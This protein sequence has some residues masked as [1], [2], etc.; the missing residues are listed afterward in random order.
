MYEQFEWFLNDFDTD[1]MGILNYWYDGEY[2]EAIE[3]IEQFTDEDWQKLLSSYK[4]KSD[5]WKDRM[6]YCFTDKNNPYQ[7]QILNDLLK[8]EN[9]K[10][11]IK[12]IDV[13]R[14]NFD[15]KKVSNIEEVLKRID[16]LLPTVDSI[17]Q[18]VLLDFKEKGTVN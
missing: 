13:I 17:S 14:I 10:L 18:K 3:M 12:I 6:V 4:E 1:S 11:F 15:V 7:V 8:T 16:K 2:E 5:F 9:D